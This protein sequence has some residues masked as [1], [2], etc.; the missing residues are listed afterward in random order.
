MA[1][2]TPSKRTKGPVWFRLRWAAAVSRNSS[3]Y[4]SAWGI[5]GTDGA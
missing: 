3:A 1:K 4:S 2:G 5:T